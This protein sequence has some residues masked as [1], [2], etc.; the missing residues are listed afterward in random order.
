MRAKR[1]NQSLDFSL[2]R[3][4]R[5]RH[6]MTLQNVSAQSG[7]SIAVLSKLERNHNMVELDTL[8]RLARVFNL[9]ASDLL[10][11]IESC[12]AHLKTAEKYTSGPFN[13][14]KI[15]F[16]GTTLFHA[17]A[18]AGD[19]LTHPEAHGDE[20]EICWVLSG[21]IRIKMTRE[22]HDLGPG[23]ALKFDAVLE[24]TYEILDDAELFITHLTK[25]HRF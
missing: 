10:S 9:S 17:T 24:H 19:T 1:L 5:K 16:Q 18:K 11:L 15:D 8:Y 14:S 22:Q 12:A 13:F 20:Y 2:V 7:I 4:L 6:K 23:E 25:T 3:D 21:R